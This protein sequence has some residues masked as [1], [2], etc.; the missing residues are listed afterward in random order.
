M[1]S[2]ATLGAALRR[3]GFS[4]DEMTAHGVRAMA[5]TMLVERLNIDESIVEAPLARR[6]K[7]ALGRAYNRT[8]FVEQRRVMLQDWADYL[9]TLRK[10]AEL[11]QFREA[12]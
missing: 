8:Q 9:D 1:L 2:D 10:G 3:L 12:A 4:N 5:R 7:D 6:V 11:R